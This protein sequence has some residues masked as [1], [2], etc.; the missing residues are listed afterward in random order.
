MAAVPTDVSVDAGSSSTKTPAQLMQEKHEA[1]ETHRVTIED[2]PDEDDISH[3]PPPHQQVEGKDDTA[4]PTTN[5]TAN[6]AENVPMS[7]KA[8]G[9]QKAS[10]KPTVLD[11]QSEEAFPALGAST[12]PAAPPSRA[13][14]WVASASARAPP[15]NGSPA[16]GPRPT[17]SGAPTPTSTPGARTPVT[18]ATG[19]RGG[20]MLPGRYRDSFEIDNADLDKNKSVKRVVDEVKKKYNVIVTPKSTNFATRTEFI[21]EG[22]KARV[23]EAL[24][25]V[26]KELTLEKQVKLEIPS[27]VSAQIIGKGGANIKKLE[28]QFNVRIHID[29][30]SRPAT[31]PEEIR[32]DVVEIRGNAAQVRQVYEQIT[33]QVKALQPKVD[34][35]VRGIPPE[36]YPFI[37]G[38]HAA[39]LQQMEQDRGLRINVPQYHTW[40]QQPPPRPAEVDQRPVFVPHGDNHIVVSGEQAAALEARTILEQLAEELQKELLLEEL[41]AEQILHPYIVGDRGMDPLKFLQETGCAVILPPPEHETEDIHIIGPRDKLD[42]GRNLAEELMSRKHNRAV[43][44]HKHFNDAPQ[45]PERHSRALAQYLQQKAIE[46]EFQNSHNAEI[47]FPSSSSASPSWTVIS[48]DPQKA[49]SAR[50][51]LS[52]ITQAYPAPRLQLVEV[53]PFFHQHLEQMHASNLRNNLGVHMIVPEDGSDPV[54]LVY[55]GPAQEGPF[56]IPRNKPTTAD[57]NNFEKALQE[58]QAMLLSNIPHQGISVQDIHVPKK[59][60]DKVRRFVNNEPQP[61]PPNAFPVQVDFGRART[62]Q[63]QPAPASRGSPERVY[64]RGPSEA[65]IAGL[66]RKI[67]QFLQEA[68]EDE[69]ERGYTISFPFPAQFNKNLI[70]KQGTNIKGL[71]EKHDVEIDTRE[72]GKITIQGPQKKAEAC[73]AEILRLA[74]QWEDEVNFNV[75]IDP[76]YHGMLVGRNGE[77]LQKIQSKVDNAVRIDFPKAIKI[78][79]DAS[80]ADDASQVGG[81]RGQPQDEIRIRGPRAKAEKVRDELLSLH[82]YLVD[83]SHTATVSVA[84]GQIASLIGRRGQEMERLR[85]ETGAQIDIP[86][87]D[88]SDRVT[89]QVKGTKQQVEKAKQELQKR[90]KAFDDIVTRTLN[91]DRKHHRALIG[92]GGSHIQDVVSKAGGTGTSAEHV[93]FPRQGDES[94]ELTVKGT[95][96]VVE[97]IVQAIQDFVDERENQ[98]TETVDVP[99]TQHRDL[100]GPNG[101]IRKQ[102][103]DQFKVT[104]NVPRQGSGQTGVRI[105]GRPEHV[106]SAKK[107][108]EGK[109]SKT[110]AETIMVPRALHHVVSKNGALFRELSRDG[111]KVEHNGHKP[112]P[113]PSRGPRSRTTNGDM[114]LITDQPGE[115]S[116][117]W[118]I[119]SNQ[120]TLDGDDGEIP[121]VLISQKGDS[122]DAVNKAKQK[123]Q[124]LVEKA[125]EPQFTGYLILPDPRLHRHIIGQGGSTINSIRNQS[126]CDIQVPNRNSGKGEEGEAITIVGKEDGVISARDLILEEIKRA[127]AGRA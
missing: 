78:S 27:T 85:A 120:V 48:N 45:G 10:D 31:S 71:R 127:Q 126:G 36:F 66:R 20:V 54:V 21:A 67:E 101:S 59:Y 4:A 34:L 29:R 125:K 42:A 81:N 110:P 84:Q 5:G 89:I 6:G 72:N 62:A 51:E 114:P 65:D 112:P 104:L 12:R 53:D 83:N 64:L 90:S 94:T 43:D 95:A 77:N 16:L 8:A 86:K 99:V 22:P 7:D 55:E 103:E 70:G 107:H 28:Q 56:S 76:K 1:A 63:R 118:D 38:Q 61:T 15:M 3:P 105:T 79:D 40:R 13:P 68:E 106:A 25:H 41:A 39:R 46:R 91:V 75:K 58:A 98:I 60:H 23:T 82:Q 14:G 111:V 47:V 123:I 73:K 74:K 121:W 19:A 11:T 93:R 80:V 102:I 116:H 52:K 35:P 97:K 24:M 26:S 96:D 124:S 49:L 17:S 122:P 37:A 109:V 108:I 100:I 119:V 113:K 32:M 92:S 44:M 30:D 69:K 115:G 18:A 57:I 88:G 33:N 87:A 50:N 117:S 2:V 9:K